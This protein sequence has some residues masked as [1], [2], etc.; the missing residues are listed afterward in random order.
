VKQLYSRYREI[1]E[2]FELFRE[3]ARQEGINS[4]R[5]NSYPSSV[6]RLSATKYAKK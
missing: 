1:K 3:L 6:A 5:E 4:N 2:T